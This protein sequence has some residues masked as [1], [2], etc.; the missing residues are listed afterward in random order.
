MMRQRGFSIVELMVAV[1]IGML[2][3]LFAT[4]MVTGGAKDRQAAI[5]GSDAMQNGM[6]AMFSMTNDANQAGFG[7]N[8]PILAGCNTAMLATVYPLATAQRNSV[9]IT[10]LASV[11]IV[12]GGLGP[13]QISF[14]AGGALAGTASVRLV[15]NFTGGTSFSIDRE[16]YGFNAGDVI[17]AAPEKPNP[18]GAVCSLRQVS[19]KSAPGA[20][21]KFVR[22]DTGSEWPL[23]SALATAYNGNAARVF[24]LGPAA[25]LSFH[26]WSVDN[27][28]LKLRATD[29]P[30][31]GAVPA[32]VTDNIVT[33][34]AQYGFDTRT[35]D[36]FTP[37]LGTKI[38]QWSADMID[39]D[40]D[41]IQGGPGDYQRIVAVR[42]AVVARSKE[43][44]RKDAGAASC[45]ATPEDKRPVLFA[46]AQP[47]GVTPVSVTPTVAVAG[48]TVEWHCYRY[49]VF[50]SIIPLRNSAWRPTAWAK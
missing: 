5:T 7:L 44:E 21:S 2:A 39:A 14:S 8:D 42:I 50:E 43:P 30:N 49:R 31:A 16:P 45:T 24:N 20:S 28:Y 29:I 10:P 6:L 22:F 34:K 12:N 35:G 40:N 18:T 1:V 32:A 48:D 9:N 4:R 17:V 3:L 26:T 46:A 23:N 36:N 27:G 33:I 41:G 37:E 25:K 11:V 13:D 19:T 47:N 38:G 15:D